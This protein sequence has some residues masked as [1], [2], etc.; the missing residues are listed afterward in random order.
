MSLEERRIISMEKQIID[1]T[2]DCYYL[3]SLICRND[4]I[5]VKD[6][7]EGQKIVED[8]EHSKLFF[9]QAKKNNHVF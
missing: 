6:W 8:L 7:P 9:Q 4:G 3:L 1:L 5:E 2:K